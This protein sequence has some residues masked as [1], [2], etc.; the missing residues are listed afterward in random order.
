MA[1]ACAVSVLLSGCRSKIVSSVHI[2]FEKPVQDRTFRTCLAVVQCQI[3][4]FGLE[5]YW[6]D[7]NILRLILG[8]LNN[9]T[10]TLTHVKA[11]VRKGVMAVQ[12]HHRWVCGL[13]GR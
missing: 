6:H 12:A 5:S 4:L 13:H 1:A 8:A 9:N 3:R 7:K 11:A 10:K 2:D